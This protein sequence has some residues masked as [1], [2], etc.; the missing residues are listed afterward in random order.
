[1]LKH[2]WIS[3]TTRFVQ[4][5][6]QN[7][8]RFL[9]ILQEGRNAVNKKKKKKKKIKTEG[10]V[11]LYS[12]LLC[13]CHVARLWLKRNHLGNDANIEFVIYLLQEFS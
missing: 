7:I 13:V 3:Q 9:I 1:M 12:Y 6:T 4:K 5:R 8:S 11:W 10:K 2:A